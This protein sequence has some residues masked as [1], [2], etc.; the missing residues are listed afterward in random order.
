MARMPRFYPSKKEI[1]MEKIL[2]IIISY[3]FEPWLDKCLPS[4]LQS[5]TPCDILVIDNG[6]TDNTLS[7]VKKQYPQVRLIANHK[8]LGFGQANNI[9]LEIAQKENYDRVLL[10]NQDAWLLPKTLG[11]L[12]EASKHNLDYGIISPVHLNKLGEKIEHGFSQYVGTSDIQK[13]PSG[14]II[15]IPFINA[16]IW[17]LPIR[18]INVVGLFSPLFF[19]YGEDKDYVNR[20]HYH[21]LKVGYVPTAFGCHDREERTITPTSFFRTEQTYHLSEYANINYSFLKA[22]GYG[23]LACIKKAIAQLGQGEFKKSSQYLKIAFKL[24]MKS[25]QVVQVRAKTKKVN[26]DTA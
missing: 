19:M 18:T 11:Q 20:I 13:L 21:G 22:F 8:N 14:E 5:D 12:I 4:L 17:Y 9:G 26:H 3:N 15:P 25:W 23:L 7:I 6:S 2:A 1:K 16:A 10:I 24:L